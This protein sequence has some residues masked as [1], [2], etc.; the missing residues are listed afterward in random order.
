MTYET[1]DSAYQALINSGVVE[2]FHP[3]DLHE[4]ARWMHFNDATP[5]QAAKA[6]EV[7]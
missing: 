6:F 2:M 1:L 3:D 7:A 4:V 5:N